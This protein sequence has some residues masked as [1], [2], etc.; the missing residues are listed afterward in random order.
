VAEPVLWQILERLQADLAAIVGDGGVSHFETPD[1]VLVVTTWNDLRLWD[2]SVGT[3]AKGVIYGIRRAGRNHAEESTG[4][5]STGG[6]VKATVEV[7]VLV[8]QRFNP[9]SPEDVPGG[10][11]V[12]ERMLRDVVRKLLFED[13]N[14][15]GLANNVAIVG[16]GADDEVIEDTEAGWA[17]GELVFHVEYTYQASAP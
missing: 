15:G 11:Q 3:T 16:Q 4:D 9:A 6:N 13:V 14:L 5:N 17:T 2:T 12:V 8:N 10:A 1:R 7:R